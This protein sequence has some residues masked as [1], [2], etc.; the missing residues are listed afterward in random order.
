MHITTT[1]TTMTSTYNYT[2]TEEQRQERW[3]QLDITDIPLTKIY[4]MY[5]S[6][7]LPQDIKTKLSELAKLCGCI[8][9]PDGYN[10]YTFVMYDYSFEKITK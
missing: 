6:R 1:T 9:N 8:P 5:C 7:T 10:P 4:E 3:I 2:L